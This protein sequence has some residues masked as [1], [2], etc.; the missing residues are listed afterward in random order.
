MT[1]L[2]R[3]KDVVEIKAAIGKPKPVGSAKQYSSTGMASH[4]VGES[5]Q[6]Y[7]DAKSFVAKLVDTLS[8][9]TMVE[10]GN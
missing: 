2:N 9:R 3:T 8:D 1:H 5:R 4:N 10:R 6:Q 7:G